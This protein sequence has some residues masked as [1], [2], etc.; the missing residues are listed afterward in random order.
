MNAHDDMRIVVFA[1]A[2]H[3]GKVKTRLMPA[4]S[5]SA[6]AQLHAALVIH[7]LQTLTTNQRWPVELWCSPSDRH[8]FFQ[9]CA[10]RFPITLHTQHGEDLGARMRVAAEAALQR[11]A[12]LM[13]VGTDCPT[14]CADDITLC[15]ASLY[16]HDAVLGPAEDGGY[17]L[18]GLQRVDGQLFHDIPWGSG[19]VLAHTRTRLQELG[20]RWH[21]LKTRWDVDRPEDVARLGEEGLFLLAEAVETPCS[22]ATHIT[23]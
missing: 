22:E 3:P 11:S 7:T 18:L 1:K 21:E 2:P 4:F 6:A 10:Q 12:H 13:L 8:D 17:W 15:A 14:L 20:W 16:D 23:P 9:R 19:R 5:A